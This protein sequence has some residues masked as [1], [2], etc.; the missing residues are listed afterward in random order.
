MRSTCKRNIQ[1]V[2]RHGSRKMELS[3]SRRRT[4]NGAGGNSRT[5]KQRRNKRTK[6]GTCSCAHR[7][8]I[9]YRSELYMMSSHFRQHAYSASPAEVVG[10]DEETQKEYNHQ[11][12]QKHRHEF[13]VVPA[14]LHGLVRHCEGCADEQTEHGSPSRN[15]ERPCP[16]KLPRRESPPG[17]EESCLRALS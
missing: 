6:D 7:L 17:E 8:G 5:A 11:K 10:K 13:D 14:H 1:S 4:G 3:V 16:W 2:S 15:P 9:L 12:R